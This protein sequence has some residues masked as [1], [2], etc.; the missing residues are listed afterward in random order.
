M[1]TQSR[2]TQPDFSDESAWSTDSSSEF[3]IDL[4][5]GSPASSDDKSTMSEASEASEDLDLYES[6]CVH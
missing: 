5:L 4:P 6:R 3:E 2:T 1:A